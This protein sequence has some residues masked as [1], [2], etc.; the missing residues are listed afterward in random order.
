MSANKALVKIN[1]GAAAEKMTRARPRP[2]L[3]SRGEN[4]LRDV[5]FKL[6]ADPAAAKKP[7]M[8]TSNSSCHHVLFNFIRMVIL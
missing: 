6:T 2:R 1:C 4:A 5:V 3:P 8:S 7:A